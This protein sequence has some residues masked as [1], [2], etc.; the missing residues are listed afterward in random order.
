[1]R[2]KTTRSQS[3]PRYEILLLLVAGFKPKDLV[4]GFGLPSGTVYRWS[5]IY[6]RARKRL[7]G[8]INRRNFTPP[9]RRKKANNLDAGRK[10]KRT[11]GGDVTVRY[12]GNTR[13]ERIRH[14]GSKT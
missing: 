5:G 1:M 7:P 3:G 11:S 6:A 4:R 10:K 2:T 12:D 8:V 13:I 9:G 14:V